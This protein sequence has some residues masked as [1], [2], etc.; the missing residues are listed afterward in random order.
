MQLQ[1]LPAGNRT[2]VLW[3]MCILTTLEF[4]THYFDF[5]LLTTSVNAKYYCLL[6]LAILINGFVLTIGIERLVVITPF[7]VKADSRRVL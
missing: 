3:I 4:P 1:G 5:H 6:R 2:R 7:L